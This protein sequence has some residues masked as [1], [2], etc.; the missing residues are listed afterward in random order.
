MNPGRPSS[1]RTSRTLS[2]KQ[3]LWLITASSLIPMALIAWFTLRQST[4]SAPLPLLIGVT[5]IWILTAA[6]EVRRTFVHQLRTLNT[7]I[8]AIRRQDYSLRSMHSVHSGELG[9]LFQQINALAQELQNSRQD[10]K[11]LHNLLER[12]IGQIDVAVIACNSERR[13][14]LANPQAARL[15]ASDRGTL[16]GLPLTEAGIT[17]L[18]SIETQEIREYRFAGATGRWK[19]SRQNLVQEGRSGFLLFITDLEQ[20][21]SEE[22]IRAWQRLIRVIAHE[23]NN[24]LTPI[25]S[26]CQTLSGTLPE[27]DERDRRMLEQGLQLIHERALHLRNFISDY[28]RIARLPEASKVEFDILEL[29]RS[30]AGMY[31]GSN[32]RVQ[33]TLERLPVFG[34][35]TQLEQVFI[36]LVKNAIEANGDNSLPVDIEISARSIDCEIVIRDRGPGISNRANLFVPFYTTKEQ[37]AGI[38]L[39]LSR[40]IVSAHRG[41]IILDNRTDG[42]G[43]ELRLTLPLSPRSKPPLPPPGL[44][45]SVPQ[46]R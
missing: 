31:T 46:R 24:T 2:V 32:I 22:E 23:V 33:S 42:N 38:G 11:E 26:L 43:A 10:E 40:R 9:E 20:V 35:Q 25:T 6:F 17:E 39:T 29:V 5:T 12:I 1:R 28:T 30:V 45:N 13:I 44:E 19:I 21:L 7:L 15:L 34:D 18:L 3:R 8:E 14:I 36:N 37:G 4:N 41:S 27:Q 16:Q